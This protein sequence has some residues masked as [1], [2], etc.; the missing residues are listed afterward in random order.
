VGGGECYGR[1]TPYGQVPRPFPWFLQENS[2]VV[3]Y[4]MSGD[5]QQNGVAKRCNRTP[6]DMVRNMLSYSMLQISLWME[7]L[8]TAVHILYR[9]PS[10][11]VPKIPY[12]LW[13]GRKP[14]LNYLHV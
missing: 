7:V 2:I 4:S 11:L 6:M 9:V 13:T 10:K 3:Q 1:H 8:K 5:P 12:E 14:T